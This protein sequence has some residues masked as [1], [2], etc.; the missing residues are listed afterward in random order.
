MYSA[1]PPTG[2]S[3]GYDSEGNVSDRSSI[4]SSNV[5]NSSGR[6]WHSDC[7]PSSVGN[8]PGYGSQAGYSGGSNIYID[9]EPSYIGQNGGR[10]NGWSSSFSGSGGGHSRSGLVGSSSGHGGRYSSSRFTDSS[11]RY[12][13][14]HSNGN[15]YRGSRRCYSDSESENDE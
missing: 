7:Y 11:T 8:D 6:L 2:A 15:E 10:V 14:G 12:D 1:V 13:R 3:R 5:S 4:R 9:P